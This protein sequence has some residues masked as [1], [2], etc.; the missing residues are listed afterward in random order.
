MDGLYYSRRTIMKEI[1]I[2][3]LRP[4]LVDG[5]EVQM[6]SEGDPYRETYFEWTA[7]SLVASFETNEVSGGVLKT[8]HHVPVFRE[9]EAH[10]GAEMF[11][12]LAGVALMLFID[13][14]DG[15]PDPDTA[16]IVRI[17]PGTQI[18]IPAGKGHFVAVAEGDEPVEM[19]VVAPKMDA[20]KVAL[21]I[22]VAGVM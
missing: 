17:Q 3:D 8:W 12:F 5:I 1:K 6:P 7:S 18:I 20:P 4:G 10:V 22:P 15:R 13:Y 9:A 16:Q 21:P 19:I 14:K 2:Q 11:Y